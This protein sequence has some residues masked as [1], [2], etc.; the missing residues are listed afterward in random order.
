[1]NKI[2]ILI[3]SFMLA[4]CTQ[5]GKQKKDEA[6]RQVKHYSIGQFYENLQIYGGSFSPDESKLLV[7]SNKTG[8]FNAYALPL[9]GSEIVPLTAS[10]E[11]SFFEISFFPE[12]SALITGI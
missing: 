11:E 7:S 10:E 2:A 4:A 12:N 3:L 5:Q 6:P 8:I 9:N 1:M